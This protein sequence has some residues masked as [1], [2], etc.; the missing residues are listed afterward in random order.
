MYTLEK[1]YV[2][3]DNPTEW[4]VV[5]NYTK[6]EFLFTHIDNIL[7]EF[8]RYKQTKIQYS[9]TGRMQILWQGEWVE[10]YRLKFTDSDEEISIQQFRG[11]QDA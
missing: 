8:G 10:E 3:G 11:E 5:L 2:E 9:K 1:R 6:R 7:N 4:M